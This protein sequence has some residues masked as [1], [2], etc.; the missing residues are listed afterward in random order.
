MVQA[1]RGFVPSSWAHTRGCLLHDSWC[2]QGRGPRCSLCAGNSWVCAILNEQAARLPRII[3]LC[4]RFAVTC[5]V[6]LQ[7]FAQATQWSV[8]S[9]MCRR[10]K[11][12]HMS[13]QACCAPSWGLGRRLD[14]AAWRAPACSSTSMGGKLSNRTVW[15]K[16]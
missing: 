15:L 5:S 8:Q 7:A 2:K 14:W 10:F 3:L 6:R 12:L 11:G 16:E 1:I 9:S 13:V 4:R